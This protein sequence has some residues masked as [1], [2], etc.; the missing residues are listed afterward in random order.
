MTAVSQRSMV[1]AVQKLQ[2]MVKRTLR[3]A[4][5]HMC[6]QRSKAENCTVNELVK[7]FDLWMQL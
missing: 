1:K 4:V 2:L 5:N 3:S 6:S 7:T